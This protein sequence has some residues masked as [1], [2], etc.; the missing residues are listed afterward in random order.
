MQHL[1]GSGTPVLYI[2]RTV[3]KGSFAKPCNSANRKSQKREHP[4]TTGARRM[5]YFVIMRT[6]VTSIAIHCL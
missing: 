3:F 2:G 6:R 1:E 5:R 4:T